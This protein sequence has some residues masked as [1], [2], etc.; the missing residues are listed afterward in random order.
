MQKSWHFT[1]WKRAVVQIN[2]TQKI[3]GYKLWYTTKRVQN[4]N[5]A[6]NEVYDQL[7][8]LF[9]S[10]AF[11]VNLDYLLLKNSNNWTYF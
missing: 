9:S 3:Q 10:V 5:N 4:F 11:T 8:W 7:T 6:K 1:N 2:S